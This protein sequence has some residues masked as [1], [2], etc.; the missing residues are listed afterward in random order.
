MFPQIYRRR[1]VFNSL[2]LCIFRSGSLQADFSRY[3]S[4]SDWLGSTLAPRFFF[5]VFNPESRPAW[6]ESA[7]PNPG[8]VL[9]L[10]VFE[11]FN[12]P[13][14]FLG[15][16]LGLIRAAQMFSLFREHTVSVFHLLNHDF[17]LCRLWGR[18]K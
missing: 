8:K 5:M 17:L 13:Q 1:D 4:H 11:E 18:Q 12:L 15:F 2:R 9:I 10:A 6:T 7:I 3:L 16:R 14:T